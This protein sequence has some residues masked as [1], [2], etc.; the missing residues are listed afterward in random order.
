M[1]LLSNHF[2]ANTGVIQSNNTLT[3]DAN[4]R[5]DL[6][7]ARLYSAQ[8]MTMTTDSFIAEQSFIGSQGSLALRTGAFESTDTTFSANG[9]ELRAQ[10]MVSSNML[11]QSTNS[12]DITVENNLLSNDDSLLANNVIDIVASDLSLLGTTMYSAHESIYAKAVS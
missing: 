6:S 5:L 12:I 8:G 7:H 4:T 10:N 11:M 2:L 1:T 3:I 9:I